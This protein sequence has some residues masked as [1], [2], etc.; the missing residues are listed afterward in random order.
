MRIEGEGEG[1]REGEGGREGRR[2]RERGWEGEERK[3]RERERERVGVYNQISTASLPTRDCI[4]S[5]HGHPHPSS[6]IVRDYTVAACV[7]TYF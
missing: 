3:E 4:R 2:E 5:Y 6:G 7:D 1:E